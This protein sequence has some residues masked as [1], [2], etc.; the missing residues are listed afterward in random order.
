[1]RLFKI[2]CRQ[3]DTK[4]QKARLKRAIQY[5]KSFRA[6]NQRKTSQNKTKKRRKKKK[7]SNK[8]KQK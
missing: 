4:C 7:R 5:A 8:T 2:Q 6:K 1:M 3:D